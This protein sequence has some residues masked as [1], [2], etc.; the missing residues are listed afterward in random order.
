MSSKKQLQFGNCSCFFVHNRKS[1]AFFT[2]TAVC[3]WICSIH[4]AVY[5][6]SG[7][8]KEW[9]STGKPNSWYLVMPNVWYGSISIAKMFVAD[10]Q[11]SFAASVRPAISAALAYLAVK[12]P[13]TF[14]TMLALLR[15]SRHPLCFC[16]GCLFESHPG[17]QAGRHAGPFR[18]RSACDRWTPAGGL[19]PIFLY[20][21]VLPQYNLQSSRSH[22]RG[23]EN[24]CQYSGRENGISIRSVIVCHF[25]LQTVE[26]A[27][28]LDKASLVICDKDLLFQCRKI[29]MKITSL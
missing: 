29:P 25:L 23:D 3:L 7:A 20:R 4:L 2:G 9:L 13:M 1:Y 5:C 18:S 6:I 8:R 15:G 27:L 19:D 26:N 22:Q 14:T 12:S 21:G 17:Y 11:E 10:F 24:F 16:A 28:T